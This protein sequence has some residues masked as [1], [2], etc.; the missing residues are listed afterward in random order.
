MKLAFNGKILEFVVFLKR[1]RSGL[2]GSRSARLRGE[3]AARHAV[4]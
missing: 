3:L 4:G 2:L 1:A